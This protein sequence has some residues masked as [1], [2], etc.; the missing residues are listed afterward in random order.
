MILLTKSDPVDL[1]SLRFDYLD[2]LTKPQELFLELLIIESDWYSLDVNDVEV[3]YV[4]ISKDR[5]LI[6]F[7][8]L[9][10]IGIEPKAFFAQVIHKL[11]VKSIYCKSY[12][13]HLLHLCQAMK[14]HSNIV[15]YL[16]RDFIDPLIHHSADLSFRYAES[17]DLPFLC[18]QEDEVFEPKDLL[19]QF[20]KAKGIVIAQN[21]SE[22]VGCG[23]LT[24]I[25]CHYDHYDIGVW[26]NP[27]YRMQG[28][29]TQIMLYLKDICL[30]NDRT[31]VAACAVDNPASQKILQKIGF[32]TRHQLI[33]YIIPQE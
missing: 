22:I 32:T 13:S 28:L 30:A 5:T 29:A 18:M 24:Q 33:E 25:S 27:T 14:Y 6:E 8:V 3:G 4:I 31:P 15:G 9:P 21:T 1:E 16:Y 11:C 23:F 20:I 7:Y 17:T 10:H 19:E 26:V 12:D 2:S